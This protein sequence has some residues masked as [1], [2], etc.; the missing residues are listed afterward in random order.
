MAFS[1]PCDACRTPLR[2]EVVT[3]RV[4]TFAVVNG[5]PVASRLVPSERP[6][7][8]L[9]CTSCAETLDAYV[10]LVEAHRGVPEPAG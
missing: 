8:Y 2:D 6:H 3:I 7:D 4:S 5:G 1:I 10:R 9:L